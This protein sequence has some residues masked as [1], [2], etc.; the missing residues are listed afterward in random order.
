M[1]PSLMDKM[2][3][4]LTPN[5]TWTIGGVLSKI[6]AAI[7][8]IP[9]AVPFMILADPKKVY[10]QILGYARGVKADLPAGGKLGVCGFCWGAWPSTK[11]CV[12]TATE[13][14][15][16]GGSGADDRST[17]RLIDAQFNGHPS[18]IV[19]TP[20]MIVDAV[21]KFKV[22]YT[23]AVASDDMQFNKTEA[24]KVEATLR[25]EVGEPGG[26]NPQGYAYEFRMYDG[27]VH[28]FCVRAPVGKKDDVNEKGFFE[29]KQQAI[30]WF[31][32][33]LN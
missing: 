13:A 19:K 9:Q 5:P 28:G 10:P 21:K 27:C 16:E 3:V 4:V 22:P 8:L 7:T 32:K 29:S 26:S 1:S 25:S 18:Y 15:R 11:L 12:E 30:D 31:N 14:V 24:E 2:N 20:Q 6:Y 23:V 33:Y 17:V